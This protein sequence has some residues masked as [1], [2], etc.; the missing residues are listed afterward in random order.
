MGWKS[1]LQFNHPFFQCV[2]L[3]SVILCYLYSMLKTT[4]SLTK[5]QLFNTFLSL[6]PQKHDSQESGSLTIR[7]SQYSNIWNNKEHI[8]H[9][10]IF[11]KTIWI[12]EKHIYKG[13]LMQFKFTSIGSLRY[14]L[15]LSLIILNVTSY[16]TNPTYKQRKSHQQITTK[17]KKSKGETCNLKPTGST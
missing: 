7:D 16:P 1:L 11:I 14:I 17:K 4:F 10:Q 13:H 8:C 3:I 15:V 12:L 5:W 9:Y 2:E 6:P